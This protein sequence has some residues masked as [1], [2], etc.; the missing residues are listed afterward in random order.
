VILLLW[1]CQ[2]LNAGA[3]LFTCGLAASV[4]EGV[5]MAQEVQQ[6][7]KALPVLEQWVKVS[8]V[9]MAF[10]LYNTVCFVSH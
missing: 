2:V 6:S 9:R 1:P 10:H 7:G 5:A 3:G 8:Q 4:P